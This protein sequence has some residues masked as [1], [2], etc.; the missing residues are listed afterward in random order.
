MGDEVDE[1]FTRAPEEFVAARDALAASLRTRGDA[2]GAREVTAL[3]RPTV[4]AWAL[5]QLARRDPAAT[6][7]LLEAGGALRDAQRRALSGV[8]G[9]GLAAAGRV[10]GEAVRALARVAADVLRES[11]RDPAT[12]DREVTTSLEAASVDEDAGAALRAGRLSRPLA[13]PSGFGDLGA[14]TLVPDPPPDPP[15]ERKGPPAEDPV[16]HGDQERED[17]EREDRAR[18]DRARAL[19]EATAAAKLAER[20]AE[21]AA[22]RAGTARED[23]TAARARADTLLRDAEEAGRRAE[24]LEAEAQ[25]DARAAEAARATAA[26][27]REELAALPPA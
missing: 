3:R 22:A 11:G 16:D 15:E 18:E 14:L 6:A 8:R 19:A 13:A 1:L 21:E 23:A 10:R 24:E 27:S 5:N 7:A 25:R 17:R 4:A 9:A 2:A 20:E 26:D 12:V